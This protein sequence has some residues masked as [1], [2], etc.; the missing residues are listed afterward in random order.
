[1]QGIRNLSK[2]CGG[3]D[4]PLKNKKTIFHE[5]GI[6]Q[7]FGQIRTQIFIRTAGLC[8]TAVLIFFLVYRFF[9]RGKFADFMVSFFQSSLRMDYDAALNFYQQIFRNFEKLF[10]FIFIAAVFLFLLHIYLGWFSRYFAEIDRQMGR[11]LGEDTEEK[12]GEISLSP[13]LIAIERKMNQLKYRMEKQKSDMLLSEKRKNDLIM[14]LAH[15]LKTP[16]ASVIGY[17]NLL[18]D[19]GEISGELRDKYLDISLGKAERLEEL[20]NEF[21]EIA[22]Y[23]L[24][25]ITLQY[26][27]INFSRLLEQLVYEFGPML[28]EKN[29]TVSLQMEEDILFSCDAD[30]M[31]RVF[32]NL[33]RN[34]VLYSFRD[35]EIR[36]TAEQQKYALI[37]RFSNHGN[38]ISKEKLERLFEQFYRLDTARSTESGGCAGL[39]LA[40]A[41][42]IVELHNGTITA[43]SE[44]EVI[45]F[46]VTL[47]VIS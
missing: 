25:D 29:L 10:Y 8:L 7:E 26:S 43:K 14:Y 4:I 37:V 34:A 18:R 9:V 32:D 45:E 2:R 15:D 36:I 47:P 20:I 1:M 33:L 40:I 39:G 35:T 41:K 44:A 31:Q 21:F 28:A 42:Q 11:L 24:S 12:A 6:Y 38:P 27:R 3:S 46:T 5:K 16:L 19:E 13:E 17:L 22:R 30:K 23:N